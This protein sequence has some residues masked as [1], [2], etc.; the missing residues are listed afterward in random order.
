MFQQ[1]KSLSK[2]GL[3]L[4]VVCGMSATMAHAGPE[5]EVAMV[6]TLADGTPSQQVVGDGAESS[7]PDLNV[8]DE[9]IAFFFIENIG[10]GLAVYTA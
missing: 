3:G 6:M 7:F 2:L 5:I 1:S 8:G 9:Q 10:D 4:V